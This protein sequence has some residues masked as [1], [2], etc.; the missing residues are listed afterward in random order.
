MYN[1]YTDDTEMEGL[2]FFAHYIP[3]FI[4]GDATPSQL[5]P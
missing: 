2:R 3:L 4:K 5:R 1:Y